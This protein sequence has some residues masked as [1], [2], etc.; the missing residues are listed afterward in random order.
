MVNTHNYRG[1]R[2]PR[3]VLVM[4]ILAVAVGGQT[5]QQQPS[6]KPSPPRPALDPG[7]AAPVL[8]DSTED[9]KIGPRDVIEIKVDDA[10]ELSRSYEVNADGTFLMSHVGRVT[11]S[12]KTPD[13]L[14]RF[15]ESRLR[16][17]YLK[18]PHVTVIVKQFN[19][20]TFIIQGMVA[21]A[22][23]YQVETRLSL[24]KLISLAG[25]LS[26]G[27]GTSAFVIREKKRERAG[28]A[29]GTPPEKS[30]EES[31]DYSVIAVNIAGFL[32]GR[33]DGN[34]MLEPG[35]T[36]SIPKADVFYVAGEV[37]A[38]GSFQLSDGMTLRQALA[39]SQGTTSNAKGGD[40][41]I[42]RTDTTGKLVEIKVDINAV[43]KNK[44]EDIPLQAND[45]IIVPN[46]RGKT[47]MNNLLKAFGM[48][49]AQRGVYRY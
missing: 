42:M 12:G 23:I 9:Y 22:G 17:N 30:E 47:V 10:E 2:C 49:T 32:R 48:G 8:V 26:D 36:V 34:I 44:V 45:L 11:A 35:D 38:P 29:P 13:K 19:S 27:H 41:S 24:F 39:L 31:G 37:N 25:G 18:D 6:S 1:A 20:H 16:G 46:S 14:A 7:V 33:L 5:R 3:I 40:S 21:K 15:L 4:M 43:L 28:E